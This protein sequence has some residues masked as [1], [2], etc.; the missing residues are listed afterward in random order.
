ML[1]ERFKVAVD[2]QMEAIDFEVVLLAEREGRSPFLPTVWPPLAIEIGAE[3]S[4]DDGFTGVGQ[5][6]LGA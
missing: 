4:D 3:E 1:G 2:E 6:V 5:G